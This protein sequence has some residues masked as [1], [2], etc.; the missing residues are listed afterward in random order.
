MSK[1]YAHIKDGK[2]TNISMWDGST[3]HRLPAGET[4]VLATDE[5]QVGGTYDGSSWGAAAIPT[6]EGTYVE[7]RMQ[8]YPSLQDFIEA[9]CEKEIGGN[10]TKWD[11][12]V[13]TYNKVRSDIPK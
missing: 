12:Y 3:S 11:A 8:S 2:V 6:F 13:T 7:K 5:T 10:S 1:R 4:L 9:Y